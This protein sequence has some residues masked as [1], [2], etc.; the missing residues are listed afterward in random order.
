MQPDLE[1]VSRIGE[2]NSIKILV[3][4]IG[5]E[6][7]Y[8]YDKTN[9]ILI[10]YSYSDGKGLRKEGIRTKLPYNISPG[11]SVVVNCCFVIEEKLDE[12]QLRWDLIHEGK[13]WFEGYGNIV[14]E[15]TVEL[16][17][18]IT[19][20]KVM[21]DE[22]AII[23]SNLSKKFKMYS[24]NFSKSKELLTLG[25]VKQ[26]NNF[27]ALK[28]V[29]FE[30]KK[31][32]TYGIVGFNGSGKSTLLSIL[33]QTKKQS[34]GSFK[35]NGRI[36]ALLELGAGFHPEL[37][38]RQNVMFNSYLYGINSQEILSKIDSIQEFAGI[39]DF[40]EKPVKSYS[41]GMYVRLAFSLAIHVDPDVLI[42]DEAL[43]VGD[44]VFQRKCYTKFEEFKAQGKTIVLVTHDLNA[45]RTLCDRASILYDGNL[46]FEG[47]SN[48][49]A[50]YYQ[51]MSLTAN[52]QITN[53]KDES[54]EKLRY[55]NGK[56]RI[57]SYIFFDG[58]GKETTVFSTGTTL[59]VKITAEAVEYIENP[60][61]GIIFKTISGVEVY[62]TNTKELKCISPS[63]D[64]NDK[65]TTV[66]SIP[67]YLNEGTYFVTL[68]ITD[69][70]NGEIVTI[71]RLIDVTFVRVLS[72][73]K[74]IGLVNL[75]VGGAAEINV[76]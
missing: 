25:L 61:I 56:A 39:G 63:V 1:I 51:K 55:G 26:H 23:C 37:T 42:I 18:A 59:R 15:T 54:L 58:L 47:N 62:G 21:N 31:G 30:V 4:N 72:D 73:S 20:E 70:S 38:G 46:V 22:T 14:L 6:V 67:N 35:V 8:P 50:N 49:V 13:S 66:F 45:V 75:N 27:W 64:K 5:S 44:E 28:D 69:Q 68:G 32:E 36:A 9:P 52:L 33:A 19:R 17:S 65:F 53:H 7:W 57:S 60:V 12:V 10:G 71:D 24:N 40:F 76:N 16:N 41:S 74:C 29:S 48:D 43:A 11:E 2:M 3:T 34:H